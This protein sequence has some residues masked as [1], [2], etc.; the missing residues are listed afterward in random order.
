MTPIGCWRFTGPPTQNG[1]VTAGNNET[2]PPRPVSLLDKFTK[3]SESRISDVGHSDQN[4]MYCHRH[5]RNVLTLLFLLCFNW[6]LNTLVA[7]SRCNIGLA[8]L[9]YCTD[10][11]NYM[12]IFLQ[13][14]TFH[15]N[16][17]QFLFLLYH[18]QTV[19]LF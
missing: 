11:R 19:V 16:E 9:F 6:L 7:F 3:A 12:Q 17:L 13:H 8:T 14:S 4:V 18:A 5:Q 2:T 15:N 10:P 1:V